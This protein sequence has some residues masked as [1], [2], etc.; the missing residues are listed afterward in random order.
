MS[1]A[2]EQVSAS[3][4]DL[5]RTPALDITAEDVALPRIYVAQFTSQAVKDGLVKPGALYAASGSDDPDPQ[6]L[7]TPGNKDG[8]AEDKAITFHVLGLVKGWSHSE[9][10]GDL[11][12]WRFD[13]PDRHPDAWVTYTYS[14][15]LPEIDD[16]VPYRWLLTRS[17][18]NTARGI[19]TV[20]V[21]NAATAPSYGTAFAAFTAHRS[22]A[23]GE[24]YVPRVKPIEAKKE[25]VEIAERLA[26]M[27]SNA[28]PAD[29]N[30]TGEEPAI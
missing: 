26:V 13:D 2:V 12:T 18:R 3:V 20:L 14:V 15:A 27:V 8:V 7:A 25:N 30:A 5:V 11:Q 21:K 10:G 1:T 6:I 4:P 17:A 29:I 23:K 9:D 28:N 16:Q 19:N 24:W 22:N